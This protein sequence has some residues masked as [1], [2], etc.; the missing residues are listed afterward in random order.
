M[1]QTQTNKNNISVPLAIVLAGAMIAGAVYLGGR[2]PLPEGRNPAKTELPDIESVGSADKI[3]GNKEAQ[4]IVVEY[5]DLECPFCKVF[6]NTMHQIVDEY[7]GKIAWV[8]RHYPIK[9]LHT[10]ATREAE[11]SECAYEQG[12]SVIFWKYIDQV[13]ATT[14][15]NDTLDPLELPKIAGSLGLNTEVFNTCLNT[16]KYAAKVQEDV[17]KAVEAGARGTPYSVILKNGVEVD[18]I[19]GAEPLT[20]I[21]IKLDKA[22]SN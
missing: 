9:E 18:T 8:Y 12:G 5:S 2:T 14:G 16:G 1:D 15:T 7:K 22:L 3:F 21:K 6:H 17:K 10:R 4:V 20:S 19:N 11:A 13:F